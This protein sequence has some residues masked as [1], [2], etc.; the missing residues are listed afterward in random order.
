MEVR[1][2]RKL[3]KIIKNRCCKD[4]RKVR[5][6][7]GLNIMGEYLKTDLESCFEDSEET[8]RG[9]LAKQIGNRRV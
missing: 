7:V 2:K 6:R 3:K 4:K 5:R 9:K 8:R 1:R